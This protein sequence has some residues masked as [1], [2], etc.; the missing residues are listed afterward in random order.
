[1]SRTW[2]Q[3]VVGIGVILINEEGK[4]LIGK[5]KVHPAPKYS[6]WEED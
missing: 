3:P 1:M 5:R 2:A 4:V 6:F